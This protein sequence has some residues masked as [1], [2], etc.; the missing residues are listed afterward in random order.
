MTLSYKIKY[1]IHFV[2]FRLR[3]WCYISAEATGDVMD[4]RRV[5]LD[6]A[7]K[8]NGIVTIKDIKDKNIP[9]IYLSRLVQERILNRVDRGIYLSDTG[10]YDEYYFL[11]YRFKQIVYSYDTAL[12]FH[13]LIDL[14]PNKIVAT[15]P[16][17]YKIN[18]I[19]DNLEVRYV[20]GDIAHLGVT[21]VETN[22]GNIVNVY[23]KERTI[24][25][26]IINQDF[27]DRETY[28]T[29]I[30]NLM[31]RSD[32]DINKLFMY[33]SKMNTIDEVRNVIEVLYE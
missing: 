24:I 3:K 20:K 8:N 12:N 2:V 25:D 9:T 28:T 17:S 1:S 13:G 31:R 29:A 15:V 4:Y 32:K 7:N 14:I 6:N 33:A 21:Q 22:V 11:Q 30:R 18:K 16:Y 5:I 26:I 19:P 10:V 27:V 23:Y